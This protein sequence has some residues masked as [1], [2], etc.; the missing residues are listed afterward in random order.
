MS[1]DYK[2]TIADEPENGHNEEPE[3]NTA[4]EEENYP[5][6]K[7]EWLLISVAAFRAFLP[8]ILLIIA[9]ITLAGYL[10]W[11]VVFGM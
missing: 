10:L 8:I 11:G 7:W 4:T 9:L 1:N 2:Q 6:P 5:L 3:S